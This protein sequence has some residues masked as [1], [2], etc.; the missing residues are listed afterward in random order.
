MRTF[1]ITNTNNVFGLDQDRVVKANREGCAPARPHL[2]SHGWHPE[3]ASP[4]REAAKAL[5]R[6]VA[7]AVT[8][9]VRIVGSY[10]PMISGRQLCRMPVQ[11]TRLHASVQG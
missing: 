3:H 6:L 2:M 1:T 7:D 4:A 9:A 8:G 5:K 10:L 11:S